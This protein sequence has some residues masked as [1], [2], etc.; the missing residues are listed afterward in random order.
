MSWT[1]S[2]SAGRRYGLALVCRVW[3][4]ARSSVY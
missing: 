3:E 4:I 1:V 2:P